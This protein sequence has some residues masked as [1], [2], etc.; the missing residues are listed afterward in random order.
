MYKLFSTNV[1]H[2]NSHW[3]KTNEDLPSVGHHMPCNEL[4]KF[5]RTISGPYSSQSSESPFPFHK[6]SK[7]PYYILSLP[8]QTCLYL[9]PLVVA[10]CSLYMRQS[11]L[12]ENCT[13]WKRFI[14]SQSRIKEMKDSIN[15]AHLLFVWIRSVTL[16]ELDSH[17]PSGKRHMSRLGIRRIRY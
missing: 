7:T 3:I 4:T 16:T 13:L 9:R 8:L 10:P 6:C 17:F 12:H 1:I 5:F 11:P 15:N 2:Q 14:K